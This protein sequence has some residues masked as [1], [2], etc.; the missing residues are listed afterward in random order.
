MGSTTSS[1]LIDL[2]KKCIIPRAGKDENGL[3]WTAYG[4]VSKKALENFKYTYNEDFQQASKLLED[5]FEKLISPITMVIKG[6]TSKIPILKN[7]KIDNPKDLKNSAMFLYSIYDSFVNT[8]TTEDSNDV[9]KLAEIFEK[10][11]I[12][13][14]PFRKAA[15]AINFDPG[16]TIEITFAYGK[17]NLYNAYEEV[18]KPLMSIH[19]NLFPKLAPSGDLGLGKVTNGYN[20]PY[21]QQSFVEMVKTVLGSKKDQVEKIKIENT[22]EAVF[23]TLPSLQMVSN[24][25]G[26]DEDER[27]ANVNLIDGK[28]SVKYKE[29]YKTNAINA[30]EGA[31]SKGTSEELNKNG[32]KTFLNETLLL[33]ENVDKEEEKALKGTSLKDIAK[34]ILTEAINVGDTNAANQKSTLVV[35]KGK[36]DL[37]KGSDWKL[38]IKEIS[39]KEKKENNNLVT[40]LNSLVNL[41]PR[42][43]GATLQRVSDKIINNC[44]EEI[45]LGF[46]S[47]YF[48][49]LNDLQKV[50]NEKSETY[51]IPKITLQAI[52]FTKVSIGFNFKDTDEAGWPMSGSLKI[53]NFWTL[54]YPDKTVEFSKDTGLDGLYSKQPITYN[55]DIDN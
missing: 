26:G 10:P 46:P 50:L 3:Y 55:P 28:Y 53:E 16:S 14:L 2:S 41:Q 23:Q 30:I 38:S 51:I 8:G 31:Y 4:D 49:S 54:N 40:T 1:Y 47:I 5:D 42:V 29:A 13:N 33:G 21:E 34:D 20:I 7:V 44:A 43:V 35:P 32:M 25:L 19:K 37:K 48:T 12:Y 6:I 27:L 11:Y 18:Y 15:P 24:T 22:G 52:L 36:F 45:R 17:C 9:S 39:D